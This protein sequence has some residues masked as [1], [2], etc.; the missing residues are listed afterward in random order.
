MR[1]IKFNNLLAR[2][3]L[4]IAFIPVQSMAVTIDHSASILRFQKAMAE[5]GV[6]E[7]Q[8]ELGFNYELGIDVKK[9]LKTAEQWYSKAANQGF[10][11]AINRLRYLEIKRS[12]YKQ[13]DSIWLSKLKKSAREKQVES[14]FLLGQM[15]ADGTAVNKSLTLS[16]KLL[17]KSAR[18]GKSGTEPLITRIENELQALQEKYST[19]AKHAE[20]TNKARPEAQASEKKASKPVTAVAKPKKIEKKVIKQSPIK[21]SPHKQS[22]RPNK[23]ATPEKV[24]TVKPASINT[25]TKPAPEIMPNVETYS[26]PMD[27]I[28]DEH[29]RMTSA[30]R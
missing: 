21:Q 9:D 5:K 7:S 11:P 3:L 17:R 13:K 10:Q 27:L 12:G 2:L 24:V 28:C 22:A 18:T 30:C 19:P 14:L 25:T 20:N 15:Y 1:Y 8:Y 4:V 29:N 23:V 26:H 6:V 16:L